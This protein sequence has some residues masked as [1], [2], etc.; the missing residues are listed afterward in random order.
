MFED[1]VIAAILGNDASSD[2]DE[3]DEDEEIA[4]PLGKKCKAETSQV[5]INNYYSVRR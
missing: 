2:I 5:V 1:D 3:D 4:P